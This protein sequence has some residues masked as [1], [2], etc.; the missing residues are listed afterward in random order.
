MT[1]F[2]L[3]KN[4]CDQVSRITATLIDDFILHYAVAKDNLAR[5]FDLHVETYKHVTKG[6]AAWVRMLK[7]QYIIHRVFKSGGLLRKY[8]NHAEVKRR[9]AEEQQFLRDQLLVPWRFC[10]SRIIGNPSPDIYEMEDVFSDTRFMLHS[11]STTQS[12]SEHPVMLWLNLISFNGECW[13]TFGPVN[14]FQSFDPD[15]IFFF[16]TELN[17]GIDNENS[18]IADVEKN[19]VPYMM[20]LTG[21]M[22]PRTV[23]KDDELLILHS[24][25]ELET[26]EVEALKKYFKV[27]YNRNVFRI[28]LKSWDK[29]PHFAAAY[30]DEEK[31]QFVIS[32]MTER[33]F[34]KLTEKLND[35]GLDISPEPQVRIHP[36]M[37]TTSE[38]IL[39]KKLT[40][41]P[42]EQLFVPESTPAQKAELEKINTFLQSVLPAI[43]SGRN[44]NIEA[45]ARAAGVDE[46]LAKKLVADTVR[47]IE[48]MRKQGK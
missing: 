34:V 40:L 6:E 15:D 45:L 9:S 12:L 18:L 29:P 5:E 25:E 2:N 39:K 43:N 48:L 23:N 30:F 37:L 46:S 41:N 24:V 31:N 4:R 44:I 10:F 13:E 22:M 38:Q 33:S 47:R 36:S 35:C 11:R 27:E 16:A 7:S 19:P 21:S 20:L 8:L 3:L 14:A 42:Y 17:S 28:T 26:I 32:S 1:D